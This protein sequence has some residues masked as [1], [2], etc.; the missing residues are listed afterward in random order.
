MSNQVNFTDLKDSDYVTV[1]YCD[2]DDPTAATTMLLKSFKEDVLNDIIHDLSED[3]NDIKEIDEV[4]AFEVYKRVFK[5][6]EYLIHIKD[7]Q[8]YAVI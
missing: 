4:E 5:G 8:V 2:H 6:D 1:F 3:S 7:N